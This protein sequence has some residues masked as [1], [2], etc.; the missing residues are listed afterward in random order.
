MTVESPIITFY[1]KE[2]KKAPT[3]PYEE[4]QYNAIHNFKRRIQPLGLYDEFNW[5]NDFEGQAEFQAKVT[6]RI[7]FI[8]QHFNLLTAGNIQIP[9]KLYDAVPDYITRKVCLTKDYDAGSRLFLRDDLA[10]SLVDVIL[11]QK[12]IVLL[13]DAGVGK[14]IELQQ[15]AWYFST[16]ENQLYPLLVSLNKYVQKG[17][18]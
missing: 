4:A 13:S 8:I 14:T 16:G 18:Q 12:R 2:N 9:E 11:R 7:L 10:H 15:A 1:F 3:N 6:Q 5:L 17:G